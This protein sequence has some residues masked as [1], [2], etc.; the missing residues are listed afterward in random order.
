MILWT[1]FLEWCKRPD[2]IKKSGMIKLHQFNYFGG[3]DTR[4]KSHQIGSAIMIGL[5]TL[6]TPF[7]VINASILP[8]G[9]ALFWGCAFLGLGLMGS[10]IFLKEKEWLKAI[11][12][13]LIQ[14]GFVVTII[15]FMTLIQREGSINLGLLNPY[16]EG[17]NTYFRTVST[18]TASLYP[19]YPLLFIGLLLSPFLGLAL[20]VI[21]KRNKNKIKTWGSMN[22]A[23][24]GR[25]FEW[26]RRPGIIKIRGF[27][28]NPVVAMICVMVVI[29]GLL[30]ANGPIL[31][32]PLVN[33]SE[34][35]TPTN[36]D[37]AGLL[38]SKVNGEQ[39]DS[40]SIETEKLYV[41]CGH[42]LSA[43]VAPEDIDKIKYNVE[44]T[45]AQYEGVVIHLFKA[46][47]WDTQT[48]LYILSHV[49]TKDDISLDVDWYGAAL[50]SF[51]WV[52]RVTLTKGD[53]SA[54]F[55]RSGEWIFGVDAENHEIRNDAAID[56]F[57]HLKSLEE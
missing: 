20:V 46:S 49:G 53:R 47:W 24:R 16:F 7:I 37:L 14:T 54:F 6:V 28:L 57:Q 1:R 2:M 42:F 3:K 4:T 19:L 41:V 55:W 9:E 40:G 36:I 10:G 48:I 29:D 18:F 52:D 15:W 31:L 12:T 8:G 34:I 39:L 30:I 17:A 45:R 21:K 51:G 50:S 43:E 22:K 56:L 26:C 5:I 11:S 38:P 23:R 44:H 33:I 13:T 32:G 35:N 27:N 25:F